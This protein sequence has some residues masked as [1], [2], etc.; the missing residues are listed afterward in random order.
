MI[1]MK[2]VMMIAAVLAISSGLWATSITVKL[3]GEG[4]VN[5]STIKVGKKVSFD[6]F[7]ENDVEYKGFSFGFKLFSEDI[8]KITHVAD[9]GNGLS[10]QGDVKGYNGWED[11]SIWDFGGV[12]VIEK[13][14]DGI[15]PDLIG[16]GGLCKSKAYLPHKNRKNL[17]FDIIFD[18][19]GTITID[20]SFYP[21]TGKWIFTK[22]Q[23]PPNWGGPYTFKVVK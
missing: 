6:L 5:D 20:S 16:F 12:Y 4:A 9:K 17:S 11:A 14:W 10:T 18:E 3:S 8:K 13:D 7:F 15:L 23:T 22:P 19:P 2:I 21:P 1:K